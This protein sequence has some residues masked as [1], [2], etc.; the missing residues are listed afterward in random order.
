M[1]LYIKQEWNVD[2]K[3]EFHALIQES[4]QLKR[5]QMSNLIPPAPIFQWQTG[6]QSASPNTGQGVQELGWCAGS[7]C[8]PGTAEMQNPWP[9]H[10]LALYGEGVLVWQMRAAQQAGQHCGEGQGYFNGWRC[11]NYSAG[12]AG[13][14]QVRYG[15][16]ATRRLQSKDTC[17]FVLGRLTQG[18]S[19]WGKKSK[20]KVINQSQEHW[21]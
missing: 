2:R 11:S 9:L 14:C 5:C 10:A 8:W 18:Q 21:T 4:A 15:N 20:F 13:S 17:C 12:K 7:G 3:A 19:L 16:N 6:A 1:F